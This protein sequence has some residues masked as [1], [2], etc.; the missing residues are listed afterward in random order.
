MTFALN[1]VVCKHW[2][3]W[4]VI[5]HS[6]DGNPVGRT[7]F[8]RLCAFPKMKALNNLRKDVRWQPRSD[9]HLSRSRDKYSLTHR[10]GNLGSILEPQWT[11]KFC[12]CFCFFPIKTQQIFTR[13]PDCVIHHKLLE[14]NCSY[15][16]RKD[17]SPNLKSLWKFLMMIDS[18][19]LFE[20]SFWINS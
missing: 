15:T 8:F 6:Q 14:S 12:F 4:K 5:M 16:T 18:V 9:F 11:H 3:F 17:A 10:V 20:P 13:M 19:V 1:V 2:C 7:L